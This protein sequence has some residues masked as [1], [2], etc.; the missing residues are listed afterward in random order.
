MA[1]RT[2][3]PLLAVLAAPVSRKGPCKVCLWLAT[4]PAARREA[5]RAALAD[6]SMG[7]NTI[8]RA[9]KAGGVNNIGNYILTVHREENH[10]A[11]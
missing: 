5:I 11:A 2:A 6:P 3:D 1:N 8:R 9:L 4:A 10:G 7:I